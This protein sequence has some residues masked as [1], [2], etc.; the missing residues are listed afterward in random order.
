MKLLYSILA[1]SLTLTSSL[2]AATIKSFTGPSNWLK[3]EA[4]LG[5]KTNSPLPL[6]GLVQTGGINVVSH[7]DGNGVTVAP[8]GNTQLVVADQNASGY[9][10]GA[11]QMFS[12]QLGYPSAVALS[13]APGTFGV[14]FD[15]GAF[16]SDLS[17]TGLT[18]QFLTADGT[19][20]LYFSGLGGQAGLT[21]EGF[22]SNKQILSLSLTAGPVDPVFA[23]LMT[24][25]AA[26]E[27]GTMLLLTLGGTALLLLR[28]RCRFPRPS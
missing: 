18:A 14:G 22:I 20:T 1:F 15:V 24:A 28:R 23:N 19:Q 4:A 16:P 13:F 3:A 21:F 25:T 27:P 12:G 6:A 10:F 8:L 5:L 7:I 17:T 11:A 26:P 2:S 9:D